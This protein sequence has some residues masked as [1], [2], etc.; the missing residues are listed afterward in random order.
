[1]SNVCA[2]R[3]HQGDFVSA[4][5]FGELASS[6]AAR[7]VSQ[8]SVMI[9]LN[10]AVSLLM[11]GQRDAAT[12]ALAS[13]QEASKREQSWLATMEFLLGYAAFALE[14]RDVNLALQLTE[15]AERV[16]W[17]KEQAVPS[18]GLFDKLKIHRAVHLRGP[19]AARPLVAESLNRYR[20]RHAFYYLDAVASSAWVE[21]LSFG[22]YSEESKRELSL[23][24]TLGARGLRAIL[25]AQGFLEQP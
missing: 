2:A 18:R 14:L 23:F 21:K 11:N 16:A 24:D 9:H 5:R 17:G 12:S 1:M 13:A 22:R 6:T 4:V 3:L 25:I 7:A 19:E 15:A 8:R 10:F 20:D